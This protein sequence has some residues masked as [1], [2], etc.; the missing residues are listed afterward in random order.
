MKCLDTYALVEIHNDNPKFSNLLNEEIVITD[1]TMAEFYTD[2]FKKYNQQ[3]ADYWLKKLKSICKP[4]SLDTLIK[5]SIFRHINKKE[6]YSY[7]DA[8]GYIYSQENNMIFVTG[9]KAFKNK[10]GVEFIA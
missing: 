7:F 5:A 6:N 3:T 4:L 8:V 2:L 1:I 10:N 9:D